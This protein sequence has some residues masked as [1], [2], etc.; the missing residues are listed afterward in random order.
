MEDKE[1]CEN[2]NKQESS[3]SGLVFFLHKRGKKKTKRENETV[4]TELRGKQGGKKTRK[5]NEKVKNE[6]EKLRGNQRN[7][8]HKKGE[9]LKNEEVSCS[10]RK[11]RF[12]LFVLVSEIESWG[13]CG[14]FSFSRFF[15]AF[16]ILLSFNAFFSHFFF[17]VTFE[18]YL[19]VVSDTFSLLH[20]LGNL[21]RRGDG[22]RIR[23]TCGV[24]GDCRCDVCYRGLKEKGKMKLTKTKK[25]ELKKRFWFFLSKQKWENMPEMGKLNVKEYN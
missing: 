8:R 5:E 3:G 10:N 7:K 2:R 13:L 14:W 11:K 20:F 9:K 1:S 18:T 17:S 21:R 16:L 6:E 12:V 23:G 25:K 19:S 15:F 4:R 24:G 22:R